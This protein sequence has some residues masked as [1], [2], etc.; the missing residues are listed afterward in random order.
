M[1]ATTNGAVP[2]LHPAFD[3][4]T[5]SANVVFRTCLEALS[6]PGQACR[7]DPQLEAPFPLFP[8]SAAV[9][10][11]LAD[12]EATYWTDISTD[13]ACH[14]DDF[15]RFH[16]GARST[17]ETSVA[18]FAIA[19]DVTSL[20]PL[21]SFKTGT[22]DYPD[23]STTILC[24]VEEIQS[25]GNF[26]RGPGIKDEVAF[27]SSPEIPDFRAE[28]RA[29]RAKFPCGVDLLFATRTHIAALPR[30]VVWFDEA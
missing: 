5:E 14:V 25:T 24:Q 17:D 2:D 11:T 26:F 12:F 10:L 20:P 16:T 18:D 27:A 23:R 7:L 3:D 29:N 19:T 22:H 28:M 6:R 8:T 13:E 1:S 15:L 30:S 21:A 4:Y 9:L